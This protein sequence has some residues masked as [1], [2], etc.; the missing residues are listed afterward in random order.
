MLEQVEA[1]APPTEAHVDFKKFMLGQLFDSIESDCR[2]FSAWVPEVSAEWRRKKI[3][4]LEVRIQRSREALE[5]ARE[6]NAGRRAWVGA[7]LK[8]LKEELT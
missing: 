6:R 3:S 4:Q 5:E 7:L 1:W 8:S 2:H